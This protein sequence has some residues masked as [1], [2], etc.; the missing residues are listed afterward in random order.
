MM[1]HMK[2]NVLASAVALIAVFGIVAL[3]VAHSD[4]G[5]SLRATLRG[6]EEPPSVITG[7]SGQFKATISR[8]ESTIEYELSYEDLQGTV[9]QGHIHVGQRGVNGGISVWLC[10][11][12]TNPGPA[13]TPVCPGPNSGT[14]TGTIT[15]ATVVGPSGQGVAA[16]EFEDLLRAIRSG[17]TYANVHSS[18]FPGGEVRGQISV[19]D[20]NDR[21]H[22]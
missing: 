9:T 1:K 14:V 11:T 16:G 7:A 15:A 3:A 17:V 4:R 22:R 21:N 18:L 8:D 5:R 19:N 6:I 2:I 13:G 10:G 20:D 12:A